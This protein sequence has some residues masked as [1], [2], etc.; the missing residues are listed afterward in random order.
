M[1]VRRQEGAAMA[2]SK[3]AQEG[4]VQAEADIAA[5]VLRYITCHPL[6]R[7]TFAPWVH[8]YHRLLREHLGVE[9]LVH[10]EC[11][12]KGSRSRND[13][14]AE[15]NRRMGDEVARRFGADAQHKLASRAWGEVQPGAAPERG[16]D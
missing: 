6:S 13:F 16:G 9:G 12:F 4:R 14:A 8:E 11:R 2:N 7:Y 10:F 3:A 1:V 5:G 15:Y